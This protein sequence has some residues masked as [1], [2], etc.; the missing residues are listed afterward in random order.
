MYDYV[1]IGS[2]L[3]GSVF[4]HEAK[5]LGK[6]CIVLDKRSH[7]GGNCYTLNK[8]NIH[9]H[10]YGPHIF[11]TSSKRIWDYV[12]SHVEFNHFVNRPKVS[13]KNKLYSFP[14]NLFTLY[15]LWGVQS[16]QEANNKLEE[17]RIKKKN[18]T[19]SKIGYFLRLAQRFMKSLY[20]A[21]R[22]N[23]GEKSRET[24]HHQ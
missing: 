12:N 7:I 24:F 6:K 4:A 11:H 14:I 13:Y 23:N 5:K 18:V 15:Q 1:I 2:G 16:P 20:M 8:N 9:I 17:V 21:T 19:T 22:R 10:A 3:F